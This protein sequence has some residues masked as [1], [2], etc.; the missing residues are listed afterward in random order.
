[1]EAA[2]PRRNSIAR[3]LTLIVVGALTAAVFAV[4]GVALFEQQRQLAR[5]LETKAQSLAQYMAQ[6]TPISVLSL[7][8]VE[9]NN[10]VRK[11][12][13]TDDE[14]VYAVLVNDKGI[15]LAH[16]AREKDPVVDAEARAFW[17]ERNPV[18]AAAAM[19]RSARI[20]EVEVPITAAEKRIGSVSVGF[21]FDRMR[22]ALMVQIALIGAVLVIVAGVALLSIE[23]ALRRML[24]PVKALTSAATQISGGD[25]NVVLTGTDRTDEIGVLARAFDSMAAQLRALVAGMEQRMA[26]LQRMGEAL[27]KSEEEFRRIVATANEGIWVLG[28][29]TR[30]TFVNPVMSEMLG[31]TG[32]AM[33]GRPM[34]DFMLQEDHADH[35][36]RMAAR[37][38]GA[39]EHYERRFRRG[40]GQLLWAHVSAAPILD[41]AGR[42]AGSFAMVTDITARKQAEEELKRYRD[43]LEEEVEQRM[44]DLVLARNAA[45]AANK[46]KSIFLAGMSH[47]LRTPLNAILGFSSLM[48]EDPQLPESMHQYMD[49]II[50][51]GE[52][53][54]SI[55]NDVLEMAKIE[56]GRVQLENAPFDLGAMVRDVIEMMEVRARRKGLQLIVDQ[57][58]EFPRY[59]VGDEARL[60]QV[61]INLVG[62][63]IK[64][65]TQ[66]GVTVRLGTKENHCS[67]LIIEVEDS[68]PGIAYEDQQ[69]IFEP[70]VQLGEQR[71]SKGTGL[72]LTITRQFVRMMN[73]EIFLESEPGRGS[74]FRI[75][76]P[77]TEAAED[78]IPKPDHAGSD[79]IVGLASGQPEYRV[80]IV[81]DQLENQLLLSRLMTSIGLQA[82]VAENGE[83]GVHLFQDWHP[84]LIWMDRKMPVMDG[85]AATRRIRALPGGKEVKI[86]AVTASAFQEE[87]AE[88]LDAGM[89]DFV[90]KPYRFGEIYECLARQLGVRYVRETTP[91]PPAPVV[92]LTP[93]MFS[94]LPDELRRELGIA[95]DSL[96]SER[97]ARVVDEVGKHDENL[98]KA[99][100]QYTER[101]DY[102]TILKML[103]AP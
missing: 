75:D 84:H 11:M 21:S 51:S 33:I 53:L 72:G 77:L 52:H 96:E 57:A 25:L 80:L 85:L 8:F 24:Q 61:L 62:N 37:S 36:E 60:R 30:T 95:L 34:N 71:D 20:L 45:E 10:N 47:E 65:T 1:M 15:P 23:L 32:E 100:S 88:M 43:R 3:R 97:I 82:K 67:H 73:G 55:I 2:V 83:Q 46:A 17:A 101:F 4:G 31:C 103:Q 87:R 79:H 19:K 56:S 50:R 6:V 54:L 18:A 14:A 5:A 44:G 92:S 13:L 81:E 59:I 98:G 48:H 16:Y 42:Y 90:R 39:S 91:E 94:R 22:H 26:E 28:P 40:D 35:S 86:V 74:L 102:P 99:L 49:I 9:M 58:S 7:N 66:G 64:F 70:F 27:K 41:S 68:G 29:D 12:V 38:R 78:D 89:D 69:R 76:L 93:E 63:A